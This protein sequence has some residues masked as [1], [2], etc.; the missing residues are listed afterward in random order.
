MSIFL[1]QL[2]LKRGNQGIFLGELM[3]FLRELFVLL[4]DVLFNLLA[5]FIHIQ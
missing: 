3:S 5:R 1:C 4:G 2:S